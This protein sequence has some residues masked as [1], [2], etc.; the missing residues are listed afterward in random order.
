MLEYH[1][2]YDLSQKSLR[3]FNE[4]QKLK[5][6]ARNI[7]WTINK[8]I[9][10]EVAALLDKED[11][12]FEELKDHLR[13][14]AERKQIQ[15]VIADFDRKLSMWKKDNQQNITESLIQLN[16]S[17]NL[18]DTIELHAD[19]YSNNAFQTKSNTAQAEFKKILNGW[20]NTQYAQIDD[21]QIDLELYQ[22]KYSGLTQYFLLENGCKTKITRTVTEFIDTIIF[23]IE[24]V[25][26][27]ADSA[28]SPSEIKELLISE[29][30][31]L[32]HEL[33]NKSVPLAIIALYENNFPNLIERMETKIRAQLYLM[34]DKRIIYSK[35]T[36]DAP[37]PKSNLSHFN[38]KE[39]GEVDLIG[40]FSNKLFQLKTALNEKLSS[41]ESGLN[42]LVGIVD[43]NLDAATNS[44]DG[45]LALEEVKA[46]AKEG[47]ERACD[48]TQ[49]LADDLGGISE[50][51]GVNLKKEIDK[52]NLGV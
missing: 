30:I 14:M 33:K 28:K 37:I 35:E 17:I 47:L 29:R 40:P 12:D 21:F 24:E 13:T 1:L 41:T 18:A 23:E 10:R 3:F 8:D 46:I 38:P 2:K 16:K 11:I 31:K 6:E 43:Y 36:Y 39:L 49:A 4:I 7:K 5:C 34:K 51:I 25:I 20:R 26:E 27:K 52:L 22:L 50:I 48:R 45:K 44:V 32:H 42:D 15:E 19:F 9:N